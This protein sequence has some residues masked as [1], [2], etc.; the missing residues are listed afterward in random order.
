MRWLNV[1]SNE[2]DSNSPAKNLQIQKLW[3]KKKHKNEKF[4]SA[5]NASF[6]NTTLS[7]R[8]ES[9]LSDRIILN[10]DYNRKYLTA[11]LQSA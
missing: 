6:Q 9:K 1:P 4:S 5:H 7:I 10:L 11:S 8:N 2:T 3:L